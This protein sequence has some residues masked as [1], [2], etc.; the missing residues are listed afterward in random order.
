VSKA[1]TVLALA[2][3]LLLGNVSAWSKSASMTITINA[4]VEKFAEWADAGPVIV[5]SD[6]PA[7]NKVG[8]T[9]TVSKPL[10]LY[11]NTDTMITAEG[12]EN[13]GILRRG[14]QT[15]A[16]EYMLTGKLANPDSHFKPAGSSFGEF[17]NPGNVYRI[18]HEPGVGTYPLNLNVQMTSPAKEAVDPGQYTCTIILTVGW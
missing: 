8:Q 15:L 1:I 9:R 18:A 6:W 5:Q 17:F 3:A 4:T 14:S 7:I 16:T 12:G 10:T 2:G 13:G 11:T